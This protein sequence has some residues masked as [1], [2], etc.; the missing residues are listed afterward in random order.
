MT[1]VPDDRPVYDERLV[2]PWWAWPAGVLLAL[3]LAAPVHGGAG[4]ARA[5][6]PYVV[7]TVLAV[8]GLALASRGRIRIDGGV[9]H[10]PGARIPVGALGAV[11]A[12]DVEAT[13]RLRGPTADVRAHVA[14]RA[15]LRRAVQVR[16]EDPA[17]DTPYWL[18]TSRTPEA[19][20]AALE[21]ARLSASS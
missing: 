10:V 6:V 15:W 18:I 16:V 5:V 11:R 3:V 4:G 21:Q 9:L 1:R 20:A 17:D 2:V 13:R 19:L 12:L 8:A 7:A 14:A